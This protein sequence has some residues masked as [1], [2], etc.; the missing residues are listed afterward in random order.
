MMVWYFDLPVVNLFTSTHMKT[1][2]Y[3]QILLGLTNFTS[4]ICSGIVCKCTRGV[5]YAKY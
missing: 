4:S 2:N 5:V 1:E 3:I